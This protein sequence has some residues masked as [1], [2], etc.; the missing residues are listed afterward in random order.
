[1]FESNF[2]KRKNNAETKMILLPK[3]SLSGYMA[4]IDAREDSF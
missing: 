2:L 1:V 3:F 4:E